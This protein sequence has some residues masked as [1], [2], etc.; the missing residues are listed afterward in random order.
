VQLTSLHNVHC[1]SPPQ[2]G[3]LQSPLGTHTHVKHLRITATVVIVRDD[4]CGIY[5]GRA[6]ASNVASGAQRSTLVLGPTRSGKTSSLLVPNVLLA[7]HAVVTTS[8]KDDVVRATSTRRSDV[9]HVLLFDPSGTV[10][11]PEGVTRVGWSPIHGSARWD[12]AVLMADSLADAARHRPR[13]SGA[14]DHWT[15]RA[16]ALLAPLL[17]AAALQ[18]V[19]VDTLAGWVDLREGRDALAALV[20]HH[21]ERHPSS[22]SLSGILA[23]DDRELSGIW[24]TAS[25]VLGGWRTDA[26]R[27][28]ASAPPLDVE[29]FLSGANTLH[30]V[31]PSRHQAAAAPLVVGLLDT[32][33]HATYDRQHRGA[34]LLLALDELA[35]V[36]PLPSLP[37][38]VSEGAS[39]GVLVLGCLQDLSQAR[40]RWGTAAEG[41][42]SLF[43]TT[44][45]LPGIA[46]RSTLEQLSALSGRHDVMSTSVSKGRR[47]GNVVTRSLVE[48]PRL[49]PDVIARGRHGHGLVLDSA[50]RLGWV[51]LTP[52]HLDERFV[53]G[54][55]LS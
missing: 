34:N 51:G 48:R 6:P 24:S 21:G 55:S 29:A 38:I 35:N 26:A 23:T 49:A 40:V 15:E 42:L 44:V 5:L 11:A 4:A 18:G 10:E 28:A 1:S 52:A 53:G 13:G 37:S 47:G 43:P 2:N 3:P 8:T 45:V 32:L 7:R 17:H 46:D 14:V 20:T 33:V 31:S 50:K 25:G 12:A 27:S 41:F 36:A 39:Q 22:A 30:V 9:G 16:S 54:R 19:G